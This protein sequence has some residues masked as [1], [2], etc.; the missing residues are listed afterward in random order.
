MNSLVPLG[1]AAGQAGHFDDTADMPDCLFDLDCLD[2]ACHP[3]AQRAA[4]AVVASRAF[5]TLFHSDSTTATGRARMLDGSVSRGPFSFW[6]RVP[7]PDPSI[8]APAPD[9]PASHTPFF[10]FTDPSHFPAALAMDL[11]LR[12]PVPGDPSDAHVVCQMCPRTVLPGDRHFVSCMHGIRLHSV[13]HDP[14]VRAL[15]PFLDAVL[16]ESRVIAERGGVRGR[17]ALDAWMQGPGAGL[18]HAPDIV[19][20]DFDGARSYTLIDVK[21]LDAAGTT[22]ISSH[23]T[24]R[25]R[26]TAHRHIAT[27]SRDT[28]YGPL[29]P[30]MRLIIVAVSSFGS[31]GPGGQ[32]FLS[33]L[34]RRVGQTVPPAL[35]PHASWA[36]PRL[37][38]MARMAL[39][40]ATRRGL[41]ASVCARWR[42][43]SV[44][45]DPS[46]PADDG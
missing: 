46:V 34:G 28:E 24:D 18:R 43:S 15:I 16:G 38:P 26:L 1:L 13:C 33:E 3:H 42:R 4:S 41:A 10:A 8:L 29:P 39:A 20:T 5:L 37:A 27:H 21:T 32:A 45:R 30:R 31:I 11:L 19:L 9:Q 14:T 7:D 40:H 35:L 36:T 12:P 6:R 17:V 23:H 25:D 22:H 44:P 2:A